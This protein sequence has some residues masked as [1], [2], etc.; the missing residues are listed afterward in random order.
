M[1]TLTG[2]PRFTR[3]SS[4]GR[5]PRTGR[6]SD[7]YRGL[8][9]LGHPTGSSSGWPGAPGGAC[10]QPSA[11]PC[12]AEVTF[13][14]SLASLTGG[15]YHCPVAEDTLLQIHGLLTK[16]FVDAEVGRGAIEMAP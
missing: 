8:R 13:L 14:R 10:P 15:R 12:R 1:V 5:R 2:R 7:A 4:C 11:P 9:G 16:G 6:D 3:R